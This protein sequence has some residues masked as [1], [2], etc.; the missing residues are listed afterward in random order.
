MRILLE[1]AIDTS[2][3]AGTHATCGMPDHVQAVVTGAVHTHTLGQSRVRTI[4][5]GQRVDA[6]AERPSGDQESMRATIRQACV[7]AGAV[8]VIAGCR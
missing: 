2:M 6:D 1:V 5:V 7:P 8:P 4:E 3:W